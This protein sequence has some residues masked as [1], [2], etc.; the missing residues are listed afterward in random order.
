MQNLQNMQDMQNM[1]NMHYVQNAFWQSETDSKW[2]LNTFFQNTSMLRK[3][4]APFMTKS[5]FNF[6]LIIGTPPLPM[7]IVS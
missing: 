7:I 4:P 1:Q 2:F 3:T 6:H 5:I